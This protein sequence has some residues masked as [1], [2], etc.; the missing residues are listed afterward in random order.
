MTK[1]DRL[2]ELKEQDRL[3]KVLD[4]YFD[5]GWRHFIKDIRK[6]NISS[7]NRLYKII[8]AIKGW[9]FAGDVK[10]L[11]IDIKQQYALLTIVKEPMGIELKDSRYTTIPKI[12]VQQKSGS[13]YS[14]DAAIGCTGS[15]CIQIKD[16]RWIRINYS[17]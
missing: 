10:G 7:N 5:A 15:L 3:Y 14:G 1:A 16:D 17:Q 13:I 11:M 9:E 8:A 12:W 6:H 4:K 2:Q